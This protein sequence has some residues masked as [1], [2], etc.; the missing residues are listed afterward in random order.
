MYVRCRCTALASRATPTIE[1]D[2]PEIPTRA[3][4]IQT[5]KRVRI[6]F[7]RACRETCGHTSRGIAGHVHKCAPYARKRKQTAA[8]PSLLVQI[9]SAAG[10]ERDDGQSG[11]CMRLFGQSDHVSVRLCIQFGIEPPRVFSVCICIKLRFLSGA[12]RVYFS[13]IS[14]VRLCA[15]RSPFLHGA[16]NCERFVAI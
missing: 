8:L 6:P 4:H 2:E 14:S 7:V 13:S 10:K 16:V 5:T 1:L 3:L 11:L 9:Q 15:E 12:V